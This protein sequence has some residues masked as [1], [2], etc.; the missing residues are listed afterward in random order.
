MAHTMLEFSNR[1]I[2]A[3]VGASML[4]QANQDRD[5]MLALFQ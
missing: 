4:S 3:Q 2:L 5:D 1:N